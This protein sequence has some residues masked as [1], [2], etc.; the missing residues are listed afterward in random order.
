MEDMDPPGCPDA[1]RVVIFN[2]S[3]LANLASSDSFSIDPWSS[4]SA[5]NLLLLIDNL[6]PYRKIA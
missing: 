5:S 2:I 1:A 6:R 3:P 4:F